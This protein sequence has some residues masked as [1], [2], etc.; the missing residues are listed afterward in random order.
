M[1]KG[2]R[3]ILKGR[4]QIGLGKMPGVTGLGKQTEIRQLE[5]PNEALTI[6]QV[7]LVFFLLE[8]RM[9]QEKSR[10][11]QTAGR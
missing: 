4:V 10:H 9:D 7:V 3:E 11:K 6:S 5:I 8:L 1:L 2:H